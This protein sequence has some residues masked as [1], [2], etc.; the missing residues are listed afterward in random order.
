MIL[1]SIGTYL[2]Q[3]WMKDVL[4]KNSY[5]DIKMMFNI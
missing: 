3:G 1:S 2:A 4:T 5:E